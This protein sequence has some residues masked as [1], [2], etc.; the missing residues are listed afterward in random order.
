MTNQNQSIPDSV[1]NFDDLPDSAQV[2]SRTVKAL[3]CI[4]DTTLWR[5]IAD[6]S[7]PPPHKVGPSNRWRVGDLRA[8]L[9]GR[10][11]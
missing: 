2:D 7:I 8:A 6:G 10:A 1:R 4:S 3:H 9:N 11:A 5:R